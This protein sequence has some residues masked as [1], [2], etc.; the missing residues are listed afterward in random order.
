MK[1]RVYTAIVFVLVMLAGVYI[2]PLSFVL[3]F[4]VITATSLW[5]FY[6]IAQLKGVARRILSILLGMA[7]YIIVAIYQLT[8]IDAEA[9]S[10]ILLL[11]L[12][13]PLVFSF[14]LYEMFS[15]SDKPF[16][17]IAATVLGI[18]YIGVPFAL[19]EWITL[20]NGYQ[21]NLVCGLL[22]LN[23]TNDTAAYLF[24]S[25]IGKTPLLP[26][27]SP[28]KT[29]EGT[30]SGVGTTLLAGIGMGF[31]FNDLSHWHWI[32]LALIVGVFGALGDLVESMFKRGVQI[33]DSG[34]LL[35]GHGG[36][37]DRFDAFIFIIPFATLYLIWIR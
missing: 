8:T 37:L 32:A 34:N 10:L 6:N 3:L 18:V 33:K 5:E 35:P 17:N 31:L 15:A 20:D 30:L 9:N 13:F 19:L 21:P 28:K 26:R 2:S 11:L 16:H 14:F 27:I 24:G 7:T 25:R 23:W 12:A 29:W 1:S 36:L 22:L 4:G